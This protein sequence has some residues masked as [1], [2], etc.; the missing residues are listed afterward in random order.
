M[1]P[2]LICIVREKKT[3]NKTL[4][5]RARLNHSTSSFQKKMNSQDVLTMKALGTKISQQL[6]TTLRRGSAQQMKTWLC[7]VENRMSFNFKIRLC[8][9]TPGTWQPKSTLYSCTAQLLPTKT[10]TWPMNFKFLSSKTK[11]SDRHLT[12]ETEWTSCAPEPTT[13]F[14]TPSA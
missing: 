13:R 12:E 5:S 2:K 4:T 6:Y 7:R 9:A 11:R 8:R 10:E 14:K 3:Q 1:Q